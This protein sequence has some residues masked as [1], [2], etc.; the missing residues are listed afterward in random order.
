MELDSA[1]SRECMIAT[2][3]Y[4]SLLSA[5]VDYCVSACISECSCVWFVT[6]EYSGPK[7]MAKSLLFRA[8]DK[9]TVTTMF[10]LRKD[11]K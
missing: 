6:G 1:K 11:P 8:D 10:K 5:L 4:L 3:F 9:T 7:Y 2:A